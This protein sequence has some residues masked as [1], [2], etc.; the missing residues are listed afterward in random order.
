MSRLRE[1]PSLGSSIVRELIGVAELVPYPALLLQL[2]AAVVL[3]VAG[4]AKLAEPSGIRTVIRKLGVPWSSAAAL[5]LSSIEVTAGLALIVAPGSRVTSG[6][7][8]A[9]AL[10]FTGAATLALTGRLQVECACFGSTLS[11]PLGWRQLMLAPVWAAVAVSVVAGPV[12][13]PDQRLP[14]A[15]AVIAVIGAGTLFR[16]V[17]LLAEHRTQRRIIEGSE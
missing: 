2:G 6:L 4:G 5:V 11:A 3:L 12:A 14:M 17:P 10:I 9:L 8:I 13:L 1:S 16:L 7:V 15:F